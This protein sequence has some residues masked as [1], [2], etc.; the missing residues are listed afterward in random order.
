MYDL[1]QKQEVLLCGVLVE[2]IEGV[3]MLCFSGVLSQDRRGIP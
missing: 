3:L 2:C 1:G